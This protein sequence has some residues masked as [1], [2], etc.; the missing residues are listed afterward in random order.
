MVGLG[1]TPDEVRGTLV[2]L[3]AAG[4]GIVTIGQYLAPSRRHLPVERYVP[5]AEFELYAEMAREAGIERPFCGP[6]V[7]SS[8]RAAE[9]GAAQ[10]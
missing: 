4:V 10:G 2:D 7:R 6:F 3:A 8:Y 9:V 1:E 5:P